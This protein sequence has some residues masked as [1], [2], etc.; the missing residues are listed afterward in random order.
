M[1][2][3]SSLCPVR[4][5]TSRGKASWICTSC[6]LSCWRVL[7]RSWRAAPDIRRRC[8]P[9]PGVAFSRNH[10]HSR[11]IGHTHA[12]THTHTQTDTTTNQRI[13][14]QTIQTSKSRDRLTD[15]R[16]DGQTDEPANQ[17]KHKETQPAGQRTSKQTNKEKRPRSRRQA[18]SRTRRLH[19]SRQSLPRCARLGVSGVAFAMAKQEVRKAVNVMPEEL[20]I[21]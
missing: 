17:Q 11:L 13:D 15:G 16:T 6:L 21:D 5:L 18:D 8:F 14:K 7:C 19:C 12:A 3:V 2:P 1:S 10:M 20:L 4:D 9:Q